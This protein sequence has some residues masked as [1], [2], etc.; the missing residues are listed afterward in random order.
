MRRRCTGWIFL[1]MTVLTLTF[2]LAQAGLAS[3][4][5]LNGNPGGRS[6][7]LWLQGNTG[8]ASSDSVPVPAIVPNGG[9][10]TAAQ[11]VTIGNIPGGDTAYYT[12]DGSNPKTGNNLYSGAFDVSTSE[13]V[14]AAVYD[15]AAGWSQVARATF[16]ING[17]PAIQAPVIS[18]EGGT[19]TVGQ[20]VTIIGTEGVT[21][22]TTDGSSPETSSTSIPYT[23]PFGVYQSETILAANNSGDGWSSVTSATFT[24][25]SP[26]IP[27]PMFTPCGGFFAT[28]QF[29]TISPVVG[30]CYYTTDNSDPK[31][32]S[33]RIVYTGPFIVD[34]TVEIRAVNETAAGFSS[35]D[36]A[37]L[38]FPPVI[39]PC[40]GDYSTAHAVCISTPDP[41]LTGCIYY[42]TDGSDPWSIPWP[43]LYTGP[44][45]VDHSETIKAAIR[46]YAWSYESEA[47]FSFVYQT[48]T[49]DNDNGNPIDVL[50]TQLTTAINNNDWGKATELLKQII[51]FEQSDWAFKQLG[52][53]YQEQG[54]NSVSVYSSGNAVNF[55]DQQPQII[56]GRTMI[57]IRDLAA[58]LGLSDSDVRWNAN[59]GTVTIN[60]GHDRIVLQ[61]HSSHL[62]LNG[63]ASTTDVPAQIV[64]GRMLVPLRAIGQ[65]FKK[66]VQWY[67]DGR[68]V[69][70]S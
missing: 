3:A 24:I 69:A 52:Q 65:I 4:D 62:F 11:S 41:S 39:S 21:Y 35:S 19:Y 7:H 25:N 29:V 23:R 54:N 68:I 18:P 44:I 31:T 70:I 16:C 60:H 2:I 51:K 17:V 49:S 20:Y 36:A 34:Q 37:E 22:Y 13:T 12:T 58:S 26:V 56:D 14:R 48:T 6:D 55:S 28:K 5:S 8:P 1:I 32:S 47:T 64:N 67:P 50:K 46:I 53:V 42:T 66:N 10:F 15:Q 40:G 33:T 57:P 45:I 30:T 38:I 61:N 63:A 43:I 59:A 9:A 27:W